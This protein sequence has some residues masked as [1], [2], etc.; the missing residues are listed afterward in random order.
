M[1]VLI[2]MSLT[3]LLVCAFFAGLAAM[4]SGPI[5]AANPFPMPLP[6]TPCPRGIGLR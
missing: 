3:I 5:V 2:R 4:A 6:K 1:K